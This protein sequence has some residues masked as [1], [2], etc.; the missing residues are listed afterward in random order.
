LPVYLLPWTLL[1]AAALKRAWH[2]ARAPAPV[3]TPWRFALCASV[4]FL[5]L[6]SVAATARD[7]YAAPALLG[8]GLLAGLWVETAGD[9]RFEAWALSLTRFLLW[10]IAFALAAALC[11]LAAAG[12]APG[13]ACL[14]AAAAVVL[15]MSVSATRAARA[16]RAGDAAQS[17]LFT[18]GGYVGVLVASACVALPMV[19]RW[20]NLPALAR[21]IHTD[22]AHEPLALLDPDETTIAVLDRG[23]KTPFTI[24]VSDR[25]PAPQTVANWL[26][27]HGSTAR[28]LVLLPGHASGSLTGWLNRFHRAPPPGDGVAGTLIE[29]G[30]ATAVA[31]YEL[32]QG[33]RYLL[34][35]PA[36]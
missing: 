18:Y 22:T 3:G 9:R 34:L 36:P 19:D 15:W 23:L 8:F 28:V 7:V 11:V 25:T 16:Q 1:V 4:P 10:V 32:P 17:V 27:A 21:R 31:R 6:L 29:T 24:L 30:R 33:R 13:T 12:A 5:A 2:R 35:G 26:H 20:Q 14:V